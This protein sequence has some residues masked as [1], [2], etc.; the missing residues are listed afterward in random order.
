MAKTIPYV[1]K[2]TGA[3]TQY[4]EISDESRSYVLNTLMRGL[5]LM[6][7]LSN[8]TNEDLKSV[9]NDYWRKRRSTLPRGRDGMNSPESMVAGILQNMLYAEQPQHDFSDK[10]MDAIEDISNWFAA[11]DD[12]FEPIR[13]QIGLN[14]ES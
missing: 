11:M 10:Q 9:R 12:S 4:R 14:D 7:T 2:I 13:F 1:P 6:S 3:K 8:T 5:V